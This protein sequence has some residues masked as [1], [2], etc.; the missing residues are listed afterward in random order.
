MPETNVVD[1][2]TFS[3]TNIS[4]FEETKMCTVQWEN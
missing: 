4:W 1:D 2:S 3:G